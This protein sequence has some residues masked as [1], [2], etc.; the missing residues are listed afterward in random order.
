MKGHLTDY[1]NID[2][3]TSNQSESWVNTDIQDYNSSGALTY[4]V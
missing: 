4:S 1:R 3:I 2:G